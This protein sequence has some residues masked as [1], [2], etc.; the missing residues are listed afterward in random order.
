MADMNNKIGTIKTAVGEVARI[1]YS[2]RY[3]TMTI[4]FPGGAYSEMK[5]STE[6]AARESMR[7]MYADTAWDLQ[8][9]N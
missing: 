4:V 3:Q 9:I 1:Y 2:A 8:E 6:T 7:K 5:A